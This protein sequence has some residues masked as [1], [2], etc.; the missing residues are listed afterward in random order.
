MFSCKLLESI[1]NTG[2]L[3]MSAWCIAD[4]LYK[5]VSLALGWTDMACYNKIIGKIHPKTF[6]QNWMQINMNTLFSY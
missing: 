1:V 2:I 3:K 5:T 4:Y 6:T